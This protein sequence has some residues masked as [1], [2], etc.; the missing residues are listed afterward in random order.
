MLTLKHY[1]L[2]VTLA[3]E[4]HFG[5]ASQ[6]LG[7]SQPMLTQQLKQ[8]EEIVGTLLFDRNRRRVS[9]TP[10]AKQVLPEARAVLRQAYRAESVALQAGR[11]LLG[12]LSLAY[13]GA[14]SYNG[15]LTRILSNFRPFAQQVDLKLAM[16]DLDKQ[17][18]EVTAGNLD[19]GLARLPYPEMSDALNAHVLHHDEL[20]I[21]LPAGHPAAEED[22]VDLSQFDG[23]DF[24]ATHLPPNVGFSAAAHQAWAKA[25]I[26]PNI[27]HRAPQF[28]AVIS[29]VAAGLGVA[30]VPDSMQRAGLPGVVYRPLRDLKVEAPIVLIYRR[31]NENPTLELFLKSLRPGEG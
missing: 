29:L 26:T 13:I 19:V 27:T 6:R 25:G 15:V 30:L 14:V 2:L 11:G 10:A 17:F 24:I 16:M 12:E 4:L 18:P 3:E 28:S 1:E 7:I 31:D 22:A 5:R 8:M 21:T 23:A 20:W 9:I